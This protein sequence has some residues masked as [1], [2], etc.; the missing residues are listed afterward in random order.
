M[1]SGALTRP[2][3]P[4]E[5]LTPEPPD[6]RQYVRQLTNELELWRAVA[7]SLPDI[8]LQLDREGVVRYVNRGLDRSVLGRY[9]PDLVPDPAERGQAADL[10]QAL[11]G[12]PRSDPRD[13]FEI[14]TPIRYV[15]DNTEFVGRSF[16][17][18]T[19]S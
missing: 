3:T 11:L 1:P 2:G 10:V 15:S 13:G 7:D 19:G 16:E 5:S 14:N 12:S 6:L 18:M 9:F 4:E 8:V 17:R